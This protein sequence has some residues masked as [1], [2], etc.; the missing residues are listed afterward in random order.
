MGNYIFLFNALGLVDLP[1]EPCTYTNFLYSSMF[2]I[3]IKQVARERQNKQNKQ[4]NSFRY[5]LPIITIGKTTPSY[6]IKL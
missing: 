5:L 6:N 3:A 1:P 4:T 2:G